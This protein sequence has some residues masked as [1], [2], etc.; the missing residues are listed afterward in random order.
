M[1]ACAPLMNA[2]L[3]FAFA[4]TNPQELFERVYRRLRRGAAGARFDVSFQP[5]AQLRSVI[6]ARK[7]A[8][9]VQICDLLQD[10]PPIVF[11][12]LAEIL[13]ARYHRQ[14]PS[15]EARACYL[16]YVM[17]PD[18]A[19]RI[20]EMRRLRGS[21]RLGP[22]QG[23]RL[24]LEEIF[25]S[26][27]ERIFRGQV[28]IRRIGWSRAASRTVLG[29]YDPAHGTITISRALDH[30]PRSLVEYIVHHEML[31]VVFPVERNDHR[32]VVHP[33]KFRQAERAFPAYEEAQ[34]LLKSGGW[35]RGWE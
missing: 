26:L 29:H 4:C 7:G 32:R 30:A 15:R 19:E 34:R 2:Q 12:A 1:Q 20:G 10:A 33:P 24:N 13:I 22:A 23:S 18:V 3:S 27:N 8:F 17:A 21:K 28:Q 35:G 25:T 31:H 5:W 11:E 14:K 16:A 6:R 9:D